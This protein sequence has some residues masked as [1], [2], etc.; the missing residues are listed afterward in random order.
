MTI[1]G[2]LL[3]EFGQYLSGNGFD[4][5]HLGCA[6]RDGYDSQGSGRLAA[7]FDDA[8]T[9]IPIGSIEKAG[10]KVASE[11]GHAVYQAFT[12]EGRL[13][14]VGITNDLERRW[15]ED[16]RSARGLVIEGVKGLQDLSRADAKAVEQVLI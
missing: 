3:Y 5:G 14:Y 4:S 10:S 2:G 15:A 8:T 11:G 9:F 6:L 16:L 13:I 1:V 7:A 12:A